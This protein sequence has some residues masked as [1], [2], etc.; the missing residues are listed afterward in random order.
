MLETIGRYRIES[1]LGEGAMADVYRAFD[2]GINRPLAIKVLKREFLRDRQYADR[3]LRE[4]KAAGA[5]SHPNIVTVFDVGEADGH[6]Y[7]G[8]ELLEGRSL[9]QLLAQGAIDPVTTLGIGV[10]IADALAFAH[11][12][13]V[14][15]RDIKPSNIIVSPDGR[16]VKLLDFGIARVADAVFEA[17]S[18]R[19]QVGQV[20]GTPR[21]MSPEQA[22]GGHIDG[23][24]DLF[25]LGVLLYEMLSGRRAFPG[26]S[27]AT[28]A[29]QIVQREP[30]P[31]G[32]I[33]PETPGGLQFIVNKL[34]SKQ[35]ERRFANGAQLADAMRKELAALSA[36]GNEERARA[37]QLPL[38]VR[39]PILLALITAL[40]LGAAIWTVLSRQYRAMEQV[41]LA[42]GNAISAFVA[43]N[44]GLRAV[45]N[46]TLPAGQQDWAPV[47]AFVR[48]AS[49][50]ANVRRIVVVG[51][52]GVVRASSDAALTGQPYRAETRGEIVERGPG[53][54]ITA[55]EGGAK[56]GAFRFVRP[57]T[58]AGR[59]FGQV[60]VEVSKGPL[61]DAA[62]LARL[63]MAAL[64]LVTLGGV[65]A[66]SYFGARALAPPIKRLKGA[67]LEAARGNLDFR[68]S[69]GRKDEFGEL[70]DSFNLAAGALQERLFSVEQLALGAP[71]APSERVPAATPPTTAPLPEVGHSVAVSPPSAAVPMREQD[72][73]GPT[74]AQL[75]EP[76]DAAPPGSAAT[77]PPSAPVPPPLTASA[78]PA[79]RG[80]VDDRPEPPN[81]FNTREADLAVEA[82]LAR[83]AWNPPQDRT[84]IK[85]PPSPTMPEEAPQASEAGAIAVPVPVEVESESSD[86]DAPIGSPAGGTAALP[87]SEGATPSSG[88]AASAP[89]FYDRP[90]PP[91]PAQAFFE[92]APAPSK[93]AQPIDAPT[94][95]FG[96][97]PPLLPS[98]PGPAFQP[99]D[100]DDADTLIGPARTR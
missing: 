25:S 27:S 35:P 84:R 63:L 86:L 11:A 41:A 88:V 75:P 2:P 37:T 67:L 50:N 66:T 78:P 54:T 71:S 13:G 64:G 42:S 89:T 30:E 87:A 45:E 99:D 16:V 97:P 60:D 20:L 36:V 23:R 44:A 5:L 34:L 61:E 93:P 32:K 91:A 40:V 14:V 79:G 18:V 94:P 56:A 74:A 82:L 22:L 100:L 17:E 4:A 68:I 31:L 47:E 29:I 69:H 3:F 43:S 39:L 46:A 72:D 15:H 70:F 28:L 6:P 83:S 52:D 53:M 58:Y 10:Q 49:N 59:T 7:I 96:P 38:Q 12:Q 24:S 81:P 65:A 62:R 90:Q 85:M 76:P 9:D 48:A 33:A 98:E 26:A 51:A 57:I 1:A 92:P 21:Y 55:V 73:F 80:Q 19:T 8:M 95:F 77:P